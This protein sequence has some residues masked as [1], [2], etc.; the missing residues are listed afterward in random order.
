MMP[1]IVIKIQQ[2]K[3]NHIK[4]LESLM[5]YS[6][7]HA[8]CMEILHC[9]LAKVTYQLGNNLSLIILTVFA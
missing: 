6:A 1:K 2:L 3:S 7:I 4:K 8:F 9:Y 5:L